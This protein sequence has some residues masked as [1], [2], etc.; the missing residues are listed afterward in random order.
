MDSA[1][2]RNRI[3]IEQTF[4]DAVDAFFH[5]VKQPDL[6]WQDLLDGLNH[7]GLIAETSAIRLHLALNIS[8]PS[9]G[10]IM[11]RNCGKKH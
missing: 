10:F 9:S 3:R 8:V 11:G 1:E 7:P 2:L 5:L 6:T 4:G